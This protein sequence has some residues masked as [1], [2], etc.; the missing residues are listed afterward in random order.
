MGYAY[1]SGV[2]VSANAIL[3][4]DNKFCRL[5]GRIGKQKLGV[6]LA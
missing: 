1:A 2:R 3:S 5:G 6:I 4:R